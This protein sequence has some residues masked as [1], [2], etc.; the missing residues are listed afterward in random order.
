MTTTETSQ[1]D[2]PELVKAEARRRRA[3]RLAVSSLPL[4]IVAILA[5][6]LS[7]SYAADHRLQVEIERIRAKGEPLFPQDFPPPTSIPDEENAA[8]VYKQALAALD[9]VGGTRLSFKDFI[10]DTRFSALYPDDARLIVEANA[11]SLALLRQARDLPGL[12]WGIRFPSPMINVDHTALVEQ[13]ELA[14]LGSC[15]AVALHRSGKQSEAIEILRDVLILAG[16]LGDEPSTSPMSQLSSRSLEIGTSRAI[17]VT[18]PTLQVG[19]TTMDGPK[20]EQPAGRQQISDLIRLLLDEEPLRRG[21]HRSFLTER[22]GEL[23]EI[24]QCFLNAQS[25]GSGVVPGLG[26]VR[27]ASPPGHVLHPLFTMEAARTLRYLSLRARAC[28]ALDWTHARQILA[29]VDIPEPCNLID[30]IA[31]P[32]SHILPPGLD[33]I[34]KQQYRALAL[35]RMAAMALAIRLYQLDHG[36]RPESL[37][38]LVPRYL[39][40]LPPDPFAADGRTLGYQ[41]NAVRPILFSVGED[42]R[43]DGGKYVIDIDGYV[44]DEKLDMPFFLNGDRPLPPPKLEESGS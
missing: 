6:W 27:P 34:L 16:R 19:G 23:D 17:E 28:H 1:T 42:G 35:R 3:F 12:D 36:Q 22:A 29:E 26:V 31:R 33:S 8:V 40:A 5:V 20:P 37:S 13:R 15:A 39:E 9:R 24:N 44:D 41:P 4:W 2:A 11:R 32:F 14:R 18:A 7:W 43:D 38:D 10:S 30:A 21:L 25:N